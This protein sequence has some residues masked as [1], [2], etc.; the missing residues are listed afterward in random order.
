MPSPA[1]NSPPGHTTKSLAIV[2][3]DKLDMQ[4][5]THPDYPF[6]PGHIS[7][8][9]MAAQQF[10]SFI[11]EAILKRPRE[12]VLKS[13]WT[14]MQKSKD[15]NCFFTVYVTVFI[16]LHEISATSKDRYRYARDNKSKVSTK[17]CC[18]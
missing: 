6:P 17:S 2:G 10:D 14:L 7:V 1:A 9:R 11:Q 3:L 15:A 13:L 16:L 4:P 8:P 12:R 18:C 5:E